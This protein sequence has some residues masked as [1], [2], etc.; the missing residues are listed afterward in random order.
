MEAHFQNLGMNAYWIAATHFHLG[1]KDK[2]FEWL[3][4]SYA[5][6]EGPVFVL[7]DPE[8]DEVRDDPR[9]LDFLRKIGLDSSGRPS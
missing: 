8:F 9:Y 2:G 4:R 5:R 3:E 6:K 1:D 7:I